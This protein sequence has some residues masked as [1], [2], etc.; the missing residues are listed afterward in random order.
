ME[1]FIQAGTISLPS[2]IFNTSGELK[3]TGRSIP[4][5]PVKFYEP[6][7]NWLSDFVATNPKDINLL[8]HLDYLNT[9][10][11][12]CMLV[13]LKKLDTYAKDSGNTV[14]INWCFDEDDED[15]EA[16]GE[17]LDSLVNIPFAFEE[18]KD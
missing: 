4:E 7:S 2:I 9:H 17:D 11:T 16:L 12:E 13:I 8:I 14:T 15:M 5:H 18:V 1:S 6:I 10:S 3:I